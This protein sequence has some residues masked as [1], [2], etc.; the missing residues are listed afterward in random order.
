[1]CLED[2]DQDSI[3][4]HQIEL[5]QSQP[6]NKLVSF[7]FNEIELD[8]ECELDPQLCD[9]IPNLESMLT[10]MFLHNLDQIFKPTLI[11]ISIYY[12]IES[13]IVDS[14]VIFH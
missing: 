14:L 8:C 6:L 7:Q 11:P 10:Q 13:L 12:E 5:D 9:L 2:F 3:S 4:S 1:M